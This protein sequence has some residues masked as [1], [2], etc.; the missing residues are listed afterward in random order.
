MNE[1]ANES[2][3]AN[4]LPTRDQENAAPREA[5]RCA[6][7]RS[8]E[9]WPGTQLFKKAETKPIGRVIC[10]VLEIYI[11]QR[12]LAISRDNI[13]LNFEYIDPPDIIL[14]K[15]SKESMQFMFCYGIM[16][17]DLASIAPTEL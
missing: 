3:W 2:S 1:H 17:L 6:V 12:L 7:G 8:K 13:I 14:S 9:T 10:S 15:A 16:H 4:S 5:E 11:K